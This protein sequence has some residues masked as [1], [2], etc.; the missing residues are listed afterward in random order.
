MQANFSAAIVLSFKNS[1]KESLISLQLFT[2]KIYM[3]RL[4]NNRNEN[5]QFVQ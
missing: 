3:S 5:Y 2:F 4:E 1:N